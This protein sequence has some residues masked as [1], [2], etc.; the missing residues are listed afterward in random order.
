M[1][2]C[3]QSLWDHH[4]IHLANGRGRSLILHEESNYMRSLLHHLSYNRGLFSIWHPPCI[5]SISLGSPSILIF[6]RISP[7]S[8]HIALHH[9]RFGLI[10][11]PEGFWV[12]SPR[13]VT[14]VS[15]HRTS[16]SL[17]RSNSEV[18][19]QFWLLVARPESSTIIV[20]HRLWE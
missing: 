10:S 5:T 2:S 1:Y 14:F 20:W 19:E 13:L 11:T 4:V 9:T 6:P 3:R 7:W 16:R 12:A 18:E 15:L 8:P 17:P